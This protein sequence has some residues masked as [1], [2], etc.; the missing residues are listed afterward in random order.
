M[1]SHRLDVH[2]VETSGHLVDQNKR[3]DSA[4]GL[5]QFGLQD[6][7]IVTAHRGELDEVSVLG[8]KLSVLFIVRHESP[9]QPMSGNE[10]ATDKLDNSLGMGITLVVEIETVGSLLDC[11]GFLVR[12]VS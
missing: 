6:H 5:L 10:M 8:E 1:G 3:A 7:Q 9:S 2:N 4:K 11:N 12:V